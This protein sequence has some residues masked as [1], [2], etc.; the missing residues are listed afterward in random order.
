[1]G[2]EVEGEGVRRRCRARRN[3]DDLV[4]DMLYAC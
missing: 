4:E 3:L 1:V 2:W